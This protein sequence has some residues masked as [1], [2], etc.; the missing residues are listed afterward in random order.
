MEQRNNIINA[1]VKDVNIA[2]N[3]IYG[4]IAITQELDHKD[5]DIVIIQKEDLKDVIAVLNKM[6]EA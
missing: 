1:T 2:Y 5:K 6:V 3:M 4:Y